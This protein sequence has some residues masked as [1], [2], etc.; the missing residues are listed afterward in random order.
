MIQQSVTQ[1]NANL[2]PSLSSTLQKLPAAYTEM[3]CSGV[4][5]AVNE[6][7]CKQLQM[8]AEQLVGHDIWEFLPRD[9]A[10]RSRAEFFDLIRSGEDPPI[11]Q[12]SLYNSRG[13][14]RTHELHRRLM[15]DAAGGVIGV[16]SVAFDVSQ[17]EATCREAKQTKLWL[18]SVV[19][20]IPQAVM[21]TD[22]LGFVRFV[23][24]SAQRLTGRPLHE[25][26][27]Q[28]IEK[29]MPILRAVSRTHKP[30]SFRIA[31]DEPWNGD[32]ELLNGQGETLSVW[33]SACPIMD[34]ETAFTNGVVI[35]M[36]PLPIRSASTPSSNGAPTSGAGPRDAAPASGEAVPT[37]P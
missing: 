10:A 23:N 5:R 6:A 33:L 25:L 21:V 14:F 24:P 15:R 29:G 2:W 11:I 12:R 18:E 8:T 4:V 27:G 30:L 34:K 13:G 36:K 22:S 9:E 16:S 26:I 32:V 19:D 20:A 7:A 1:P 37:L 28:Q 3:D 35:V 17:A 31:L